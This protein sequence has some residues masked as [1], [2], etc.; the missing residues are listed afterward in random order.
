[1]DKCWTNLLLRFLISSVA[2]PDPFDTDPDPAFHFDPDPAFQSDTDPTVWSG[3]GS[4]PFQRGNVHKTVRF[5]YLYFIFL[6]SRSNRTHT[7][8][9]LC[10]ILPFSLFCCAHESSLW[11]RILD[12]RGTDP[13][14]EKWYGSLRFRIRNAATKTETDPLQTA[15]PQHW[16][17]VRV[18]NS[19]SA[20]AYKIRE[21]SFI[22]GIVTRRSKCGKNRQLIIRLTTL[23][24]FLIVS[25][26]STYNL[27]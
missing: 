6:V 12:T 22:K 15:D 17:E 16:L 20:S 24:Y 18:Y 11:I 1:M 19:H 4:L 7:R 5:I 21:S 26:T 23:R 13:D 14:P 10:S 2:D 3:F 25:V 8:G 27:L 9:I